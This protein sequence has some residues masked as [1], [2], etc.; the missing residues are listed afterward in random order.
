VT[1]VEPERELVRRA[2]PFIPLV[3]VAGFALGA[4]LGGVDDGWSAT[5]GVAVVA[6][7]FVTSALSIAWAARI[8][9]LLV[10]AVA[11][12]GFFLRL[13]VLVVALVLLNTLAWFSPVAFALT[14]VPTTV[15]LLAF[16]A[17]VLF[18]RRMQAELWSF[19]ARS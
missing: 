8:S 11:L 5:I 9:P 19:E 16:E 2:L 17:R 10:A 3:A 6:G 7:N 1:R 4:V 18:G 15:A 12:A 13:V 14:V